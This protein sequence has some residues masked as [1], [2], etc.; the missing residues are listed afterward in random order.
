MAKDPALAGRDR[1]LQRIHAGHLFAG[2]VNER[3]DGA[4]GSVNAT[5]RRHGDGYVVN[6]EKYYSTGGLY[7]SWFSTTA[8]DEDARLGSRFRWT[9]TGS[10]AST[11]SMPSAND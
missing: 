5:L 9:A 2:T 8:K 4:S 1:T 10:S 7:A 3:T 6:G 11:T